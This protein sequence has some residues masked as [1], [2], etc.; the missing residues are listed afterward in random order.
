[1]TEWET[2]RDFLAK[3]ARLS[4]GLA[5]GSLAVSLPGRLRSE[6]LKTVGEIDPAA[7]R[8][9]ADGLQG[10]LIVPADPDYET[11]RHIWN[12][13]FDK[14][15]GL[16][17]R[18][19][20]SAD[21]A[22]A[23]HFARDH[24][25]LVAVRAGGHSLAGKSTCDGGMIIDLSAM[26]KMEIDPV[27]RIA[28]ADPGL[29]LGEFDQATQAVGLATT[30]GTEPST[31]IAGL[32]LGGGLGWLMG[33]HGLACDNLRAVELVTADGRTLT[34]NAAT[35]ENLYWAVRGA[36]ANFGVVTSLEYQ[37]HPVSTI[38]GGVI[39]FPPERLREVL[40]F[41][42]EFTRTIP[43]E[44]SIEVGVIPG[45]NAPPTPSIAVCYCGDLSEGEKAL[46]PLRSFGPQLVDT[47]RPMP[48]IEFQK[49]GALPSGHKVSTFARGSVVA[50]LSDA[51]IDVIVANTAT[52]PSLGGNF[53]IE[54]FHGAVCRTGR[55]DTA[56]PHRSPS[57]NFSLHAYWWDPSAAE[58]VEKW[59]YGF[60]ESMR[61]LVG[62][63]AYS[64]YLG[65][66]GLDRA[67][68]AYGVNYQRLTA[69]KKR[70]DPTNFFRQNQNIVPT[71]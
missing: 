64:N 31:G 28:R 66:E 32:T 14:H 34:V 20:G 41:Y 50:D 26:K 25:L 24:E 37:L 57:Y 48:Y 13:A 38:L 2:R 44:M 46:K 61:P 5:V 40:K 15:P 42:R 43:D 63:A 70:Y 33:K 22:R 51:M 16:I 23:V 3:A 12:S 54:Q 27:K 29:L 36:G 62:E 52:V 18:C 47:V 60:W 65:D 17:V 35:D 6:P 59:G 67:R 8:K 68:A 56:F 19:T 71:A 1:M 21:V 9:F 45:A 69:L 39:K 53:V 4:M 10:R 58:R 55:S 49:L 7:T 11:A 30:L